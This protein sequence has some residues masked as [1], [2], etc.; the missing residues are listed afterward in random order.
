[1]T[2]YA[3]L[4]SIDYFG[5]ALVPSLRTVGWLGEGHS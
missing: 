3:D 4:G 1:M 5:K 2:W